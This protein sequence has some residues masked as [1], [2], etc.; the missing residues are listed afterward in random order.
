MASICLSKISYCLNLLSKTIVSNICFH[1]FN[2]FFEL[3]VFYSFLGEKAFIS[4]RERNL[5]TFLEV[6]CRGDLLLF[7]LVELLEPWLYTHKH[8]TCQM[9]AR[10]L[11]VK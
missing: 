1:F 8:L 6:L 9:A 11:D 5:K 4:S 2:A 10:V 7:T 3:I